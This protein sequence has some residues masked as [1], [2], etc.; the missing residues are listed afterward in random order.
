[1]QNPTFSSISKFHQNNFDFLR[2]FLASLVVFSHS[3]G[4]L[5]VVNH[6]P[7]LVFT[8]NQLEFGEV[9]VD[10]F[11]V[12]S[13]FLITNSWIYS[14]DFKDY[15]KKRFLRISPGLG[16]SL[17]FCIFI[18][19][20]LGGADLSHYFHDK[21]TYGFLK[22]FLFADPAQ[23]LPGVF[24]RNPSNGVNGPLWTIR[25]E[26]GCYLILALLGMIGL[27]RQRLSLLVLLI[28]VMVGYQ[29]QL[30]FHIVIPHLAAGGF[31]RLLSYFL[32]GAAFYLYRDII[33]FSSVILIISIVCVLAGCYIG[34]PLILP[35]CGTYILFYA[36]YSPK[37][38]L[39]RFARYGDFSYGIYLYGWP[40]QQLL[41]YYFHSHL[42]PL[43]LFFSSLALASLVA[44]A[45]WHFIEAPFLKLKR[46]ANSEFISKDF[47][48][49]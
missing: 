46:P 14:R 1:M 48:V 16:G 19:G 5:T 28:V 29:L 6:D 17:L 7:L 13:G 38:H 40:L 27:L 37:I 10:F 43:T 11:F 44:A 45:S 30:H 42:T 34:L 3:F 39:N 20:P 18:I 41:I 22:A 35:F 36:A 47:V 21:H 32:A 4:M 12:I 23:T 26:F 8:R 31:P 24:T 15:I 25:Y 49:T 2:F 33:P 9:A